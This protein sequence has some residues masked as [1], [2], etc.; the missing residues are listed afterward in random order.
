[1]GRGGLGRRG[2]AV[3]NFV[4][5]GWNERGSGQFKG[6]RKDRAV[7]LLHTQVSPANYKKKHGKGKSEVSL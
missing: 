5:S 2:E 1:M 7:M 6:R 3:E 4:G